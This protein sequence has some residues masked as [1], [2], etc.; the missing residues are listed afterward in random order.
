[1]LF[2]DVCLEIDSRICA[3]RKRAEAVGRWM[4]S[5]T[6]RCEDGNMDS[7]RHE[8]K[9]FYLTLEITSS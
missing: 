8:K 2:L 1:M 3:I 7:Q 9:N 4:P 5:P 6:C